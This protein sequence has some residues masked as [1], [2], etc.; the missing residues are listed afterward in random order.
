[1][2]KSMRP[3]PPIEVGRWATHQDAEDGVRLVIVVGLVRCARNFAVVIWR[4]VMKVDV[5]LKGSNEDES[6][7]GGGG[8][9]NA[10]EKVS[11]Q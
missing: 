6:E 1:M 10:K 7:S 3:R 2:K 4:C 5:K 11:G 8:S 9:R